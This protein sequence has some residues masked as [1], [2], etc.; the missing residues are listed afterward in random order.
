MILIAF[1]IDGTVET[2]NPPGPVQWAKVR[3]LMTFSFIH[4]AIV[5]PSPFRP[6]DDTPSYVGGATR[7]TNLKHFAGEHPK[8]WLRLY[9]SDNGDLDQAAE[10]GFTYIDARN[11]A[12]GLR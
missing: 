5:S 9:V 1:D 3:E 2:G 4:V 11:F 7:A 8:V 6:K 10:A 12:N